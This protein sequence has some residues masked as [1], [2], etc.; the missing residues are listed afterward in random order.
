MSTE[1]FLLWGRGLLPPLPPENLVRAALLI[2]SEPLSADIPPLEAAMFAKD[3]MR[4]ER[5]KWLEGLFDRIRALCVVLRIKPTPTGDIDWAALALRLILTYEPKRKREA[6]I[7]LRHKA[8]AKLKRDTPQAKADRQA[9]LQFV[10][11]KRASNP[12]LSVSRIAN[13]LAKTKEGQ[14]ILPA[15]LR[16]KSADTLRKQIAQAQYE[17]ELERAIQSMTSEEW[18]DL[19]ESLPDPPIPPSPGQDS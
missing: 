5:D 16:K 9:L 1:K 3:P 12:R 7:I 6:R 18:F 2:L 19:S 4:S 11:T 17:A 8:G 13:N 10:E 15:R 14:R